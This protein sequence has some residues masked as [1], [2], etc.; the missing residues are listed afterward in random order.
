MTSLVY[1]IRLVH[2]YVMNIYSSLSA[3]FKDE[4]IIETPTS[5]G[6]ILYFGRVCVN[7]RQFLN[8]GTLPFLCHVEKADKYKISLSK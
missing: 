1:L 6:Q 8:E 2:V 4:W 3:R 5:F 7:R